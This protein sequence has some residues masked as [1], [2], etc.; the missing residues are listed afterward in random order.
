LKTQAPSKNMCICP[1]PVLQLSYQDNLNL[2]ELKTG[3]G[4]IHIFLEGACVFCP[5]LSMMETLLDVVITH[6]W[7]N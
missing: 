2:T 1:K 4:H 3:L 7:K 6:E 5:P